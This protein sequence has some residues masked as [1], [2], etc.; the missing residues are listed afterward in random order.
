MFAG[1]E[2]DEISPTIAIK[3]H[4]DCTN[5]LMTLAENHLPHLEKHLNISTQKWQNLLAELSNALENDKVP[6]AFWA[7]VQICNIN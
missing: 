4:E 5:T 6:A 3:M 1:M 7:C 2:I